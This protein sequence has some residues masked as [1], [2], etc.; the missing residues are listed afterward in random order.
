M[1]GQQYTEPPVNPLTSASPLIQGRAMVHGPALG[2]NAGFGPIL[3]RVGQPVPMPANQ[4]TTSPRIC[5][6]SASPRRQELLR[7]IGLDFV[8]LPQDIDESRLAGEDPQAYVSRVALAKA[9]AAWHDPRRPAELAVLAADTTVVSDGEILGKPQSLSEATSMLER[10]SGRTHEVMTA[11][12]MQEAGAE[13]QQ[14]RT[15]V[16]QVTF[17]TLS[18]EEIIAYWQTGEPR[19]KA[20]AYAIQGLGAMFV[21]RMEGSYTNVVGLPLFEMLQLLSAT[22]ISSLSLLAGAAR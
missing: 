15:V 3:P 9:T 22:G 12:A 6:A 1:L 11:I 8:L 19:D 18:Q 2:D 13:R 16:S 17:R 4:T 20:G 5:L 14:V 7:Q 10:L 21:S